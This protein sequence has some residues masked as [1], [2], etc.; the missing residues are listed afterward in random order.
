MT[1]T[2]KFNRCSCWLAPV[3]PCSLA[4][5][6][7]S[8]YI[9]NKELVKLYLFTFVHFYSLLFPIANKNCLHIRLHFYYISH[10]VNKMLILFA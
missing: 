5:L 9:P 4:Y 7:Y 2:P 1:F 6:N 3:N 10:N 8:N